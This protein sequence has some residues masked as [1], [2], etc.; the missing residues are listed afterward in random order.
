MA[1]TD[2]RCVS[3]LFSVQHAACCYLFERTNERRSSRKIFS[4]LLC[5]CT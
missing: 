4:L 1:V 5:K 2:L 3:G